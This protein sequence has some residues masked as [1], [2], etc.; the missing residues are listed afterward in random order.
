MFYVEI[1]LNSLV[2]EYYSKALKASKYFEIENI[3]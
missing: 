2:S 3:F 1:N